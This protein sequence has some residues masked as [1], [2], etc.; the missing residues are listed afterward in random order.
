MKGIREEER[1]RG[2]H[3]NIQPPT[4]L[5]YF[6]AMNSGN[7]TLRNEKFVI[8]VAHMNSWVRYCFVE[9]RTQPGLITQVGAVEE[10]SLRLWPKQYPRTLLK[11]PYH[12]RRYCNS[13]KDT[14]FLWVDISCNSH[15][16]Y[17]HMEN[18]DEDINI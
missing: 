17:A 10:F 3:K 18:D 6:A 2:A 7:K 5:L 12:K 13:W 4:P 15:I 8:N 9:R 11:F 1:G 14:F 16:S